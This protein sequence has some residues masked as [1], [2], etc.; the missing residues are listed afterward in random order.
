MR[1]RGVFVATVAMA[2]LVL[3]GCTPS[4]DEGAGHLAPS[5]TALIDQALERDDLSEW[6]RAVLEKASEDGQISQADYAEGMDL[7]DAC[8]RSAGIEFTRTTLLNGV[9]EFQPPPGD[10]SEVEIN[11]QAKAQYEC[12]VNAATQE[13][14]ALQ[15]ANPELLTDFSQAAVNC[16]KDAGVIGDEF[17]KADFENAFGSRSGPVDF[18]F[19]VMAPEAQTCLYSLGYTIKI[20]H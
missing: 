4:P 2:A 20:D 18:P 12:S 11:A 15:Q 1:K 19:D 9:I 8:L 13:I 17:S 5:M 16:L 7:F 6:D 10:Y 3:S 14:F